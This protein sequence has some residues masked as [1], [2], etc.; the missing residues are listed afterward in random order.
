VNV[1][2]DL[3]PDVI[4]AIAQRVADILTE[5][6]PDVAS[7]SPWM[8]RRRAA[9]YLGLPLSRLEKDKT[10]PC[11]RDGRRVIYHRDELD[12]HYRRTAK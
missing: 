12:H 8:T 5:R 3:S 11:H 7:L 2:L 1:Q 6:T 10:I 4:D 9:E